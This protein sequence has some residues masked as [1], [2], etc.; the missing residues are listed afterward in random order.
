[1]LYLDASAVVKLVT[2][3]PETPALLG[4]VRARGDM[5]SSALALVEV[6]RAARRLKDPHGVEQRVAAAL[7]RVALVP[8]DIEV[9]RGAA[10]VEPPDLRSLDAI[11]LATALLHRDDLDGLVTYERKLAKAARLAGIPVL[12]PA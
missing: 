9:V 10:H 11:H 3:E 1:M 12:S 6:T 8:I 4:L 5:I 2:S 7:A